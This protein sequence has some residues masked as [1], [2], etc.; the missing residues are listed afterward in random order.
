MVVVFQLAYDH[1]CELCRRYSRGNFNTS[2]NYSSPSFQSLK[3]VVRIRVI[4]AE[5]NNLFEI[6]KAD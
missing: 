4:G 5:I 2:K 1:I 6:P 3:S